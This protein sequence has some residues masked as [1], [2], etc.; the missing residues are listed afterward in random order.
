MNNFHPLVIKQS[1][2]HSLRHLLNSTWRYKGTVWQT[3]WLGENKSEKWFMLKNSKIVILLFFDA[4]IVELSR[5][6]GQRIISRNF[7]CFDE[8]FL[9]FRAQFH[10][11]CV[12][13]KLFLFWVNMN[14][15]F[16]LLACIIIFIISS[17]WSIVLINVRISS[18][19]LLNYIILTMMPIIFYGFTSSSIDSSI[20]FVFINDLHIVSTLILFITEIYFYCLRNFL[21]CSLSLITKGFLWIGL[22]N[23]DRFFFLFYL[24]LFL[25]WM[26]ILFFLFLFLLLLFLFLLLLMFLLILCYFS[27]FLLLLLLF[28]LFLLLLLFLL[29]LLF[30]WFFIFYC[31]LFFLHL[32]TKLF[33]NFLENF[34]G[35]LS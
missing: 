5:M 11:F 9:F 30:F 15:V 24:L 34:L 28:L 27:F 7:W 4:L 3:C 8:R 17:I 14:I 1:W 12:I 2:I 22:F 23:F 19:F 32:F 21:F 25:F 26:N 18:F 35:C 6:P 20:I 29:C 31:F 10:H 16:F 33:L 13:S